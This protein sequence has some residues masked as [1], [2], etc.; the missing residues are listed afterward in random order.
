MFG[1]VGV[2]LQFLAQT[3]DADPENLF[4]AAI[5]GAPNTCEQVFGGHDLADMMGKLQQQTV[6]RGG[7]GN[8]LFTPPDLRPSK[9]DL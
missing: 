3:R 2:I 6:F 1:S 5:L 4:I 9:I 7:K 8:G